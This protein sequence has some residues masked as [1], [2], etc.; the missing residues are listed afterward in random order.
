MAAWPQR[1][2]LASQNMTKTAQQAAICCRGIRTL[3][4]RY[5]WKE[6]GGKE[7]LARWNQSPTK[8]INEPSR[9]MEI[10]ASWTWE[11]VE[12]E[13][14]RLQSQTVLGL[15]PNSATYSLLSYKL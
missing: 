11:N 7:L 13:N 14:S 5:N 10:P 2:R 1:V 4:N 9:G 8:T 12:V 15:N 3:C 6:E